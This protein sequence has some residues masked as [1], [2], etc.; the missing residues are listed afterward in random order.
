MAAKKTA[1]LVVDNDAQ[2]LRMV[3]HGLQAE[4]YVVLT[5]SDGQQALDQVETNDLDL[6]LLDLLLPTLSGFEICEHIRTFSPL[7]IMMLTAREQIADK[8]R[9][10]ELGADD[11]VTKPFHWVELLARVRAALRRVQWSVN[12]QGKHLS[13]K[14]T[15]RG[16]TVDVASQQVRVDGRLVALTPIEYRLLVSL[17]QN[18]GLVPTFDQLLEQVWGVD[19]VGEGHVLSVNMHRLRRKL[20]PDPAHPS[21]ILTKPGFGYL[22][23][24]SAEGTSVQTGSPSRNQQKSS[25]WRVEDE[26][27]LASL[28][29][30]LEY[31]GIPVSEALYGWEG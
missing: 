9:A 14:I 21:Y 4:G 27:M 30:V 11:Y 15:I 28:P 23:P 20:E 2:I 31:A 7:P 16:L 17:A 18:A 1:I 10:F 13:G 24:V 19:Y 26:E 29:L 5:A 25:G 3:K 12:G 6:L 8:R 22:L